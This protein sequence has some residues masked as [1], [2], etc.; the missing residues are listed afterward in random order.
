MTERSTPSSSLRAALSLIALLL[1]AGCAAAGHRPGTAAEDFNDPFEHAN[2]AIFGFNQKF[3]HAIMIPVAKGYVH[4]FPPQAREAFRHFFENLRGPII[5]VN[6]VLQVRPKLAGRTAARFLLNSTLGMA[7]IV[8]LAGR[9]GIPYHYQDF[10]LTF[11]VWGIGEGPYLVVPILGPSN[12]RDLTGTI[13]EGFADPWD[14]MASNA[15]Y[16]W[17]PF[18]RHAWS[19][20]D[21]RSQY[22]DT[23]ADIERTSLD[24]YATIRS[25][26]RQRRTAL[27]HPEEQKKLP[28]NPSLG[29]GGPAPAP[30]PAIPPAPPAP[31]PVV[32][33]LLAPPGATSLTPPS[34]PAPAAHQAG[35]KRGPAAA[36]PSSRLVLMATLTPPGE[37]LTPPAA[38]PLPTASSS[39]PR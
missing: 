4:I 37:T 39:S 2:R 14:I 10:G 5:L 20:I 13:A 1:L 26:Y 23:L 35:R 21:E 9:W 33:E 29:S 25:L 28:P 3:D 12:P 15:H 22:L 30:P 38:A 34:H 17:A 36:I 19:G 32:A 31:A 24:Y 16:L 18:I 11:A 6:D 27:T 7:G 8:D